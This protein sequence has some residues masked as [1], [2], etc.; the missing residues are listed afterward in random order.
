MRTPI[1]TL[2]LVASYFT[3]LV[4]TQ[5]SCNCVSCQYPTLPM[6]GA[7]WCRCC[8]QT[9]RPECTRPLTTDQGCK[10][11]VFSAQG[12]L[13]SGYGVS[14]CVDDQ[15]LA[16]HMLTTTAP[17]TTM[18][19]ETATV[20][21]E[22]TTQ[23]PETTTQ[24]PETTTQAPETTTQAP[25]TTQAPTTT[26]STCAPCDCATTTVT[27]STT[28]TTASTTT[29]L[30]TT[31]PQTSTTM[32][33]QTTQQQTTPDLPACNCVL[34]LTPARPGWNN[35]CRCCATSFKVHNGTC[36]LHPGCDGTTITNMF[37]MDQCTATN[38]QTE[39]AA[40]NLPSNQIE[41][42]PSSPLMEITTTIK[43]PNNNKTLVLTITSSVVAFV[44]LMAVLLLAGLILY[45][46]ISRQRN[47]A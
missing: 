30:T 45:R 17:E 13:N 11:S 10:D 1:I 23:A 25:E 6:G 18:S 31:E 40:N 5:A 38:W 46:K 20:A 41:E 42:A 26:T 24:A 22:T 37:T 2:F 9:M 32:M 44:L 4:N 12:C 8:H 19:T 43:S 47:N 15:T 14:S 27:P 21:P 35:Y 34:C 3:L 39:C 36:R 16:P 7:S 29:V 33:T 28:A